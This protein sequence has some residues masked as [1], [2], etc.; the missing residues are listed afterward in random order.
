MTAR[1]SFAKMTQNV[2][3]VTLYYADGQEET[4][5]L[6]LTTQEFQAQLGKMLQRPWLVFQLPDQTIIVSSA[7]VVKI[8]IKPPL[9]PLKGD[10]IFPNCERITSMQ[11]G[12]RGRIPVTD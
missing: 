4:F 12:T 2:T 7:N 5:K 11:R 1:G 8:D 10:G 3:E 6:P 9:P